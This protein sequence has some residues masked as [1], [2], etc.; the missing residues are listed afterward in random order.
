MRLVFDSLAVG[1]IYVDKDLSIRVLNS[2]GEKH[3]NLY[4]KTTGEKQHHEIRIKYREMIEAVFTTQTSKNIEIQYIQSIY[5]IRFSPLF[6][7]EKS[8]VKGVLLIIEDITEAK[9]LSS[10]REDLITNVSHDFRTP[11]ATIKGYS[12]A[13]IDDIAETVEDKNEMAKIIFDEANELNKTIN[14]LL[15]LSRINAGHADLQIESVR[16]KSFFLHII[17]RF[18]DTFKRNQIKCSFLIEDNLEYYQMDE[19]KMSHVIYNLIDNAIRY[20]ADSS[21][22]REKFVAI[23]VKLDTVLD[24]ILFMVTDN[25]LG[26]SEESIPYIFERFFKDDKARTKPKQNGT[27][28]GLSLVQSI[29]KEHTGKVEVVSK[30]DEGTRFTVRLPYKD[31]DFEKSKS[32]Q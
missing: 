27:G 29:V 19:E 17:S 13:I 2:T 20:S 15:S 31:A 6:D 26:I 14:S 4:A 28:I 9:R 10:I 21:S 23:E 25:G 3:R 8:D 18:S 24:E 16:L 7:E 12:E 32:N 11:L 30:L 1:V 22:H 5:K